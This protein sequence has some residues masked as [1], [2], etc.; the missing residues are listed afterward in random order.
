MLDQKCNRKMYINRE[1]N[2]TPIKF[3]QVQLENNNRIISKYYHNPIQ[4][5]QHP[6]NWYTWASSSKTIDMVD[7]RSNMQLYDLNSKPHGGQSIRNL[8]DCAIGVRFYP[9]PGSKYHTLLSFEKLY[10]P[11]HH[12]TNTREKAN[13]K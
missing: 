3:I 10:G 5:S 4:A 2:R 8:N 6:H 11:T 13:A 9:P 12:Q 1:Y 7:T